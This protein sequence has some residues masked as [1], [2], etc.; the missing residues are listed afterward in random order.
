MVLAE[1]TLQLLQSDSDETV[2]ISFPER[3]KTYI[4]RRRSLSVSFTTVSTR[5]RQSRSIVPWPMGRAQESFDAPSVLSQVV[6]AAPIRG[7]LLLFLTA[8]P[9][10][11]AVEIRNH[12]ASF[13]N[14]P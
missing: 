9:D 1:A 5:R 7:I 12:L 6:Q 14:E 13:R 11:A 2:R 3:Y 4:H 10:R 8:T